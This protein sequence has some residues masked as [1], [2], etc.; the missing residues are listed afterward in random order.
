MK[1]GCLDCGLPVSKPWVR[2]CRAC[3]GRRMRVRH[4]QMR[5]LRAGVFSVSA[6]AAR[7]LVKRM[8]GVGGVDHHHEQ[9]LRLLLVNANDEDAG[10]NP[11]P[12]LYLKECAR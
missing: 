4:R 5:A 6:K 2:R 8:D 1:G 7:R 12:P 3:N 9:A 11:A 10:L